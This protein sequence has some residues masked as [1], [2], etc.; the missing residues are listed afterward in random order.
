VAA[1]DY[2]DEIAA[3]IR[4]RN[5]APVQDALAFPKATAG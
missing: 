4:H 3:N 1:L 5:P 2:R